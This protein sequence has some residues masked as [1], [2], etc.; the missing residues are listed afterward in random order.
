MNQGE[1]GEKDFLM[2]VSGEACNPNHVSDHLCNISLPALF[3]THIHNRGT[4]V[5]TAQDERKERVSLVGQSL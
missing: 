5:V 4:L 1:E 3:I 2:C